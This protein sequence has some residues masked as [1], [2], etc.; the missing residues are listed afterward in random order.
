MASL[1]FAYGD[2]DQ[3]GINYLANKTGHSRA[4]PH[5]KSPSK[6]VQF[7]DQLEDESPPVKP[8]ENAK[9]IIIDKGRVVKQEA[10]GKKPRK[11]NLASKPWM[12]PKTALTKKPITVKQEWNDNVATAGLFDP[13]LK[14]QRSYSPKERG[15]A[16]K[17]R[18]QTNYA[19]NA[20]RA[21][22]AYKAPKAKGKENSRLRRSASKGDAEIEKME[23]ELGKKRAYVKSLEEELSSE[24]ALRAQM[25]AEYKSKID[26]TMEFVKNAIDSFKKREEVDL[27]PQKEI[28]SKPPTQKGAVKKEAKSASKRADVRVVKRPKPP[29]FKPFKS[30]PQASLVP[31][32]H[33]RKQSPKP[34]PTS[35]KAFTESMKKREVYRQTQLEY[36]T[37][38][39]LK[40]LSN[41]PYA[42]NKETKALANTLSR[43]KE[44][45][46]PVMQQMGQS[47]EEIERIERVRNKGSVVE[48]ISN[49]GARYIVAHAEQLTELI[50]DDLMEELAI[51][52]NEIEKEQREKF[53]STDQQE[54]A[55]ELLGQA[56]ELEEEQAR[57]RNRWLLADRHPRTKV[58]LMLPETGPYLHPFE[59][60]AKSSEDEK[61]VTVY[62]PRKEQLVLPKEVSARVH[63]YAKANRMYKKKIESS[64]NPE[65]WKIYDYITND[66]L[67]EV[68]VDSAAELFE[69]MEQY[70]EHIIANE[71][72]S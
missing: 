62:R 10:K 20:V 29:I 31:A 6:K 68:L 60:A 8:F 54:L 72:K 63:A 34:K 45:M 64:V 26:S 12:R 35:A 65:I 18:E 59:A 48:M 28:P 43:V 30:T 3:Y 55:L 69:N 9:P 37:Q 36:K 46:E 25:N 24:K 32:K 1:Q 49:M 7:K 38:Q 4:M 53:L 58:S 42:E 33:V 5:K 51:E 52:M 23:H 39:A 40:Q 27:V 50:A 22:R 14:K 21:A 70:I 44:D 57:I 56:N 67:A 13:S 41:L 47:I 15:R 17:S 2:Q 16:T 66:I 71:F 61:L 11:T 19:S